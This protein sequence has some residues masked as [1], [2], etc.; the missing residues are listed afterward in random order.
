MA[1]FAIC[2]GTKTFGTQLAECLARGLEYPIVGEEVVQDAA[3]RLG[4]SAERLEERLTGRPTLWEPFS[5]MRR[6]HVL[7]LQAALAE[8][9]VEGNLVYHG[10]TGGLLLN[11]LPAT[12]TVRCIAPMGMRVQAVMGES[13]MDADT[14]A[15]YIRDLDEARS[16]WVRAL[17]DSNVGDPA[18]YDVMINLAHVEVDAACGM[19]ARMIRQPEFEITPAVRHRLEDFRTACRVKVALVEDE[20][21]RGLELD[22]TAEGGRVDITGRAPLHSSGQMGDRLARLARGVPGVDEVHLKIDWFDP[23][24]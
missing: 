20:A 9:V 8:R 1:I 21:L 13:D 10:L 5:T 6:V 2:R 18:L 24:P 11:G 14:A 7:A 12:L 3:E 16:H 15:S 22:A 23:Y 4:V 17:H 19:I